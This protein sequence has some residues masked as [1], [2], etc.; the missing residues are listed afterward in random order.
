MS[1]SFVDGLELDGD[2]SG[3]GALFCAY[4]RHYG[5]LSQVLFAQEFSYL[6]MDAVYLRCRWKYRRAARRPMVG[7]RSPPSPQTF[8][9][10]SGCALAPNQR[11]SLVSHRLDDE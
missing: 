11:L 6:Q 5:I 1:G 2:G 8:R 9:S 4:V 10:T 3:G 7:L